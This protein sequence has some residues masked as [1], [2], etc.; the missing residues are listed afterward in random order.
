MNTGHVLIKRAWIRTRGLQV[1]H[2]L[3][4]ADHG[5]EVAFAEFSPVHS[6]SPG[7]FSSKSLSHKIAHP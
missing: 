7:H 5:Q 1:A 3:C 2:F 4:K 6:G